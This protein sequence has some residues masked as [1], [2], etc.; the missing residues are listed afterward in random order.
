MF[1][2]I[3][4]ARVGKNKIAPVPAGIL[5]KLQT[6]HPRLLSPRLRI[7]PEELR[8]MPRTLPQD[9]SANQAE[10]RHVPSRR[11][12]RNLKRQDR[13]RFADPGGLGQLVLDAVKSP[14]R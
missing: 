11:Q 10:H 9:R 12:W 4:R 1:D 14:P 6:M 8:E 7:E 13:L 3:S 2:I 5:D